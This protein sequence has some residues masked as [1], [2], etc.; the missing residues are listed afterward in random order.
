MSVG[1]PITSAYPLPIKYPIGNNIP[2]DFNHPVWHDVLPSNNAN[3]S[4][5]GSS[6]K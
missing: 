4:V 6:S 2:A 1:S 3:G 5:I